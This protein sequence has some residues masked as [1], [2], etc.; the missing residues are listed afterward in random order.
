MSDS[1][2]FIVG[3]GRSGTTLL[4]TMLNQHSKLAIP[5]ES[6]F[7][8]DYLRA[9]PKTPPETFLKL[10]L[11]EYEFHEWAIP[12]SP[13]DFDGCLT[14][15][16]FINRA[17][18][19]YMQ[20]YGKVIWGQK[21]P[22]FV[23]FGKLLKQHY[24]G[25]KFVHVIRDPRAV[26]SSLIRS[27]VH[28]SNAYFAARR[29]LRDTDAGLKLQ[30]TYPDDVF[31]LHYEDFILN[32]EDSLHQ[33]CDFLNVEF[34]P[35]MLEYYQTGTAEYSGYYAQIHEKLNQAPDKSRIEA[36][37]K[38]LSPTQIAV[39]EAVCADK[40]RVLGYTLDGSG[41]PVSSNVILRLRTE[42]VLGLYKQIWHNYA[43]RRGYLTSF[44]RRKLALS[45][46]FDTLKDVNY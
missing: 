8:I 19:L 13:A 27:D 24:P 21:T 11:K 23:R 7:I 5:L 16:D 34:E 9:D 33:I 10:I 29:W 41:E 22:R 31:A 15:Q 35:A 36:W 12:F 18:A 37:R 14:A 17:H 4:R 40:M 32:T 26:V 6:L 25:A 45:L 38:H 42:R 43:T 20:Q 44:L 39:V 28:H 1:P 3:C 2:F 46:F 30:E